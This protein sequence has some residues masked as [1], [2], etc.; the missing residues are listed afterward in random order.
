MSC[1]ECSR[2]RSAGP[3]GDTTGLPVRNDA[4]SAGT[5]DRSNRTDHLFGRS[6]ARTHRTT[7]FPGVQVI[8]SMVQLAEMPRLRRATPRTNV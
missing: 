2:Q 5:R 1:T 4:I 7:A 3:L 8:C 6:S